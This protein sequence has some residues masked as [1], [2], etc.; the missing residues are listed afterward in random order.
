MVV[1]QG[2]LIMLFCDDETSEMVDHVQGHIHLLQDL[3]DSL[4]LMK[5]N[6]ADKLF[7]P[8]SLTIAVVLSCLINKATVQQSSYSVIRCLFLLFQQVNKQGALTETDFVVY[9][10]W[11]CLAVLIH[12]F[13]KLISA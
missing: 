2:L 8:V 10:Y 4:L 7:A 12:M 1:P 6:Q 11:K 9:T 13:K 3:H 5:N